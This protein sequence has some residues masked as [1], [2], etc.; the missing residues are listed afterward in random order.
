MAEN[1]MSAVAGV[2]LNTD[3]GAFGAD[4]TQA[5]ARL[6]NSVTRNGQS[7]RLSYSKLLTPTNTNLT[8]AAYRYSSS[9]FLST[10][11]AIALM[12]LES[13]GLGFAMNGIQRGRLQVTINQAL[14]RGYGSLYLTG[15]TQDYWNRSDTDTQFQAGY[16]NSYKRMNY[17]VSASRQFNIGSGK[18]DTRVMLTVGIPLGKNPQAPYSMTSLRHDTS[19]GTSLQETV[20]GVL[21]VDNAFS[22][23]LNAGYTT[24]GASA[25]AGSIGAN[26]SYI[27]PVAT[28][29]GSAST[30]RNYTQASLGISGGIVAYAGGVAFTPTVGDTMAIV[31]TRDAAGARLAN[32]SGLR[33]DPWGHAIVPTLTPFASNQIEIDPKGLPMS[34][35]LKSTQQHIAPTAGAIVR[36]K[37]ETDNPGRA[38][39]LRA[40][41]ADD[42]PLPFGAEVID[43]GGH[44]VGT[45]AQAGRIIVRGLKTDTGQLTVSWGKGTAGM[46]RLDYALPKADPTAA[47][48]YQ[49]V[50]AGCR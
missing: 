15:S 30:S 37:F 3:Y 20:T 14:P 26:A 27:S 4:V 46:C 34:V 17:G 19:G 41:G 32:A 23:G 11:D 1:Y 42:M 45:V 28:V 8:L 16:N 6:A 36:M 31:E 25:S 47:A 39:I 43:A 29:T 49:I 48:Q 2:A 44:S 22:Y 18:W 7:A 40:T 21:G 33:V 35:E 10:A 5:S 50:E 38:A 9:G 24:G 13:C 12:D